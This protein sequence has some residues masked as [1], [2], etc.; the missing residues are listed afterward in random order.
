MCNIFF[1][2]RSCTHFGAITF[3]QD[4]LQK[5]PAFVT[6]FYLFLS[7]LSQFA[8]RER[9]GAGES[10]RRSPPAIYEWK[11]THVSRAPCRLVVT[12]DVRYD[13]RRLVNTSIV[14]FAPA[15]DRLMPERRMHHRDTQLAQICAEGSPS[16]SRKSFAVDEENLLKVL[17]KVV[18]FFFFSRFSDVPKN[19]LE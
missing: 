2:Y 8:S 16:H 6:F 13:S 19:S 9:R 11:S 17:V 5:F 10:S 14:C 18:S 3:W 7:C 12:C 15:W 4:R 1:K